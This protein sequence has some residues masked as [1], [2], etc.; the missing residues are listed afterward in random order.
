MLN[1]HDWPGLQ[2]KKIK[3]ETVLA[4]QA[5]PKGESYQNHQNRLRF[6]YFSR[7]A[8]SLGP[9]WPLALAILGPGS[10]NRLRFFILAG[11]QAFWSLFGP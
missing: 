1:G 6:L 3:T 7:R 11:C 8:S 5:R 2:L 10:E 4:Q 9:L